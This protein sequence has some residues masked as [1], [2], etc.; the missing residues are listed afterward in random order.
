[1]SEIYGNTK[2]IFTLLV[3]HHFKYWKLNYKIIIPSILNDIVVFDKINLLTYGSLDRGFG[4]LHIPLISTNL[5]TSFSLKIYKIFNMKIMFNTLTHRNFM[6]T[7]SIIIINCI[8]Q[9]KQQQNHM[10]ETH[11]SIYFTKL[12]SR[13]IDYIMN[14]VR[15]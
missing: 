15:R 14:N 10:D 9:Q 7:F 11:S 2:L 8:F 12:N 13:S 4:P 3:D 5:K 6:K 1:M